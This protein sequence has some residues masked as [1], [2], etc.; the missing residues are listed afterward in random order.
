LAAADSAR[1]RTPAREFQLFRGDITRLNFPVD[2]MVISS[3]G[4]DFDTTETSVIGA[5]Y[6]NRQ[7]SV[8]RLSEDPEFTLNQPMKLWVSR[9]TGHS[10]I[11]RIMCVEIAPGMSGQSARN[12]SNLLRRAA[13]QSSGQT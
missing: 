11:R 8:A 7:I 9:N 4:P 2:L 6:R 3:I 12:H 13:K 10:D 1:D 5:L